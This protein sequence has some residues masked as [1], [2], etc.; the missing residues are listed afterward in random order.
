MSNSELFFIF[1]SS[2]FIRYILYASP[3]YLLFWIINKKRW[4]H[5]RIQKKYPPLKQLV[6]EFCW[7]CITFL[8]F[9]G[10]S[11]ILHKQYQYFKIYTDFSE[12][13]WVYF[14]FTVV[15]FIILHDTYFYWMHRFTHWKPIFKWV[16]AVHHQSSNPSPWAAFSFHPTE[17]FLHALFVMLVATCIPVH[18]LAIYIFMHF[19]TTMNTLGH[20]GYDFFPKNLAFTKWFKIINTPLHHNMHHKYSNSNFSLYFNLWDCWFNTN[21]PRYREEYIKHKF[22]E[23]YEKFDQP[24]KSWLMH[25]SNS[26]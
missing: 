8:T 21:H 12:Y 4:Q 17:A 14:I 24:T 15:L 26:F 6:R 9:V 13:G 16:H 19:M 5:L 7:S 1:Y 20:L 11:L 22:G 23:H 3:T 2:E 18:P 25:K 10:V